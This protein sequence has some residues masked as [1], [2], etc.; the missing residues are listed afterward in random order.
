MHKRWDFFKESDSSFGVFY[1]THY[2]VAGFDTLQHAEQAE[3]A[4]RDAGFAEDEVR[5]AES[6][7]VVNQVESQQDASWLDD[8]KA[9]I[10]RIIGTETSYID[11]DLALARRG[12]AFL[13]A[14]APD[15]ETMQQIASELKK[16]HPVYARHY[17]T[18]GVV[19]L[20]QPTQASNA[21]SV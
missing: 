12:G 3:E 1:P 6:H 20:M 18:V 7:F 5:A 4:L 2:V 13:F 11:E 21:D 10:A 8:I 17:G 19:H 16:Q 14:H 15:H 9:Q